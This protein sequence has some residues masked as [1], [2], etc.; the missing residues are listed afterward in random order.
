M[1][2]QQTMKI[3]D[4]ITMNSNKSKI[5]NELGINRPTLYNYI[6]K[7]DAG[8][9][10]S[11]PEK[12]RIFF[13]TKLAEEDG[14]TVERIKEDLITRTMELEREIRDRT[15]DLEE[16]V[17]KN[18]LIDLQIKS[19]FEGPLEPSK[20]L[21]SELKSSKTE[22]ETQINVISAEINNLTHVLDSERKK[23]AQY[24]QIKV[25][26]LET[27]NLF[28]L[29]SQCFIE[30]GRCMVFHNGEQKD[31][32][33]YILNL[34]IKFDDGY[35]CVGS[36]YQVKDRNF[37]LI[38]DVFLSAPL[39]YNITGYDDDPRVPEEERGSWMTTSPDLTTGMCELKQRR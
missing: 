32:R 22:N 31:D 14:S 5:A 12:V 6:E 28:K 9:K 2:K 10:N 1:E 37:F 23:L 38:D 27:S 36:Y 15:F 19:L 29:K 26:I 13:D 35:C 7:Y 3:A 18:N 11:I 24:E 25:P 39:Y 33:H 34:Y 20:E 17:K 21:L 16:I 30:N 4:W 8:Q